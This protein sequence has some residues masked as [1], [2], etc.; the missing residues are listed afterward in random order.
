MSVVLHG[1]G[2]GQI[3]TQS[4]IV[5][6]G[7]ARDLD[8][9]ESIIDAIANAGIDQL[10]VIDY[11]HNIGRTPTTAEYRRYKRLVKM[12]QMGNVHFEEKTQ[13]GKKGISYYAVR[14]PKMRRKAA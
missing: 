4:S 10:F 13:K 8:E 14:K 12:V 1:F 6:F 5:A 3:E 7:L 2:L 11:G 9:G